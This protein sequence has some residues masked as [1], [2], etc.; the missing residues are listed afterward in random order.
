MNLL[1][2]AEI[3]K[4]IT[5]NKT[6]SAIENFANELPDKALRIGVRVLLAL[7]VFIIGSIFVKLLVK[8]ISKA[9]KKAV[10]DQGISGFITSCIRCALYVILA[11]LVASSFGVDAATI[12]ALL[13]SAG[14]AIGLAVQGS[15]SNFAGGVLILVT[16][17]FKVGDYIVSG[18]NEGTVTDIQIFYTKLTTLDNRVIVIP[19]GALSNASLVNVSA[20]AYRRID[21][22][23]GVSYKADLKHAKEV[24]LNMLNDEPLAEASKEKDVFVDSLGTSAVMLN[25]RFWVSKDNYW[26]GKAA[27]TEKCK[28]TLDNEGILI[29]Y[30]QIDVHINQ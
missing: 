16:K 29:P 22:L 19:N 17:P 23:V 7:I 10:S 3:A 25:V 11:F 4:E 2:T 30:S 5:S 6:F 26:A 20:N 15:L 12:V 13:G 18:A 8:V 21:I 27:V 1:F 24:L 28:L 14:V 9:L